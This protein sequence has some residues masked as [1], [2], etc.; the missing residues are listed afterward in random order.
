MLW[1]AG[2]LAWLAWLS[3]RAALIVRVSS[4]W[5]LSFGAVPEHEVWIQFDHMADASRI[6]FGYVHTVAVH[7]FIVIACLYMLWS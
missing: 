3:G 5:L 2:W 6:V 4:Q 1:L 7:L